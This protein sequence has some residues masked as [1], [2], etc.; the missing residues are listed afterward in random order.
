LVEGRA[1]PH[2]WDEIV[3]AIDAFSASVEGMI[4]SFA[5][6]VFSFPGPVF[7]GQRVLAAPTVAGHTH[8]FPDL[9]QVLSLRTGRPVYILND[10]TAAAWHLSQR[11]DENRFMVV[12]VSSGIGSKIFDRDNPRG[13]LDDVDYA[14][15]IG[16]IAVDDSPQ[17]PL[18]DCG[19]RGHLGAIS[20]GRGTEHYARRMACYDSGFARSACVR[21]FAA[22]PDTL[23]NEDHLVP[24]ARLG[25]AWALN[26]V[27]HCI[28]PLARSVL[29]TV[30]AAGLRR[31]VLIGGFALSLGEL[32]RDLFQRAVEQ[33]CDYRVM[34][35]YLERLVILGDEDACLL[36]AAAYA[37]KVAP[38]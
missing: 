13:V 17:A 36:G 8:S 7:L 26:I 11:V 33:I 1:N 37:S 9:R 12:T 31:V 22:T 2:I 32:Y 25:D 23:T 19:G 34:A 27:S 6:L 35:R 4:P 5:P 21:Q 29:H 38:S 20:S 15:E 30:T 24:A 10:I 28:S 3:A 16:H 14:G 18:C